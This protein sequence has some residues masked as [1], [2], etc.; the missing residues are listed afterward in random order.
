M[1]VIT[2]GAGT[3][4]T[5]R[6]P[7]MTSFA[8]ARSGEPLARTL[9]VVMALRAS[10]GS[11]A[12]GPRGRGPVGPYWARGGAAWSARTPR[13]RGA[14]AGPAAEP[15][16]L[17]APGAGGDRRGSHRARTASMA[18]RAAA[19]RIGR[20]GPGR[21]SKVG[22]CAPIR[23]LLT[24]YPSEVA[25]CAPIPSLRTLCPLEVRGCV[26]IQRLRPL[27]QAIRSPLDR[28]T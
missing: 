16:A 17:Q 26:V 14:R 4:N 22:G 13:G 15:A 10:A 2:R 6:R 3:G 20:G 8:P 19:R 1:G 21:A 25:G 24:V 23:S 7:A 11:G 9:P 18:G 5:P 28:V 12:P 27:L